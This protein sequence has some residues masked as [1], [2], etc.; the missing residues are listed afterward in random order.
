MTGQQRAQHLLEAR[1]ALQRKSEGA[2]LFIG[3]ARCSLRCVSSTSH[4]PNLSP[5]EPSGELT[6]GEMMG[7]L[8]HAGFASVAVG[9]STGRPS[10]LP[11]EEPAPAPRQHL[12]WSA[13]VES[14]TRL[15][16]L[17]RSR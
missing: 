13:Y 16:S 1:H 9:L 15:R 5:R 12:Y 2:G 11:A 3:H 17:L 8:T 4:N 7:L 10:I 14:D 6:L